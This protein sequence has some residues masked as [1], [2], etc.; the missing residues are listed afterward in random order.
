MNYKLYP[1]IGAFLLL[2]G[3]CKEG[4][5]EAGPK[6]GGEIA[7]D[8]VVATPSSV[9]NTININGSVLANEASELRNELPG[10]IVAL[11]F[12]EGA[13]V[14]KGELLLQIDD[15]EFQAQLRKLKSQLKIA[16]DDKNRKEQ[17]VAINGVSQ[18]QFDQ[19]ANLVE[20]LEAEM[21]SIQT[22]IRS[23]KI[24][25]PFSGRIGLRYVSPGSFL[26]SNDRIA[27]LVQDD[28]VKIEF[29]VPQR[30][31]SLLEVGQKIVFTNSASPDTFQADIY[32]VEPQIDV[33]T[34][35]IKVRAKC[36]N[37]D[38]K[39]VP[40]AFVDVVL[41]LETLPNAIMVPTFVIVPQLRGQKV[42][43]MRDGKA[44]GIEIETGLRTETSVQ[45]TSGISAGDTILTTAL[46]A[47]KDNMPVAVRQVIAQEQ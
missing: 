14:K 38:R 3:A 45:I 32:A 35:T 37:P 29:S 33:A 16:Q 19:A 9:A 22:K 25:A 39:L 7:V 11:P 34:R 46:L 18:E 36:A 42:F 31:A 23:T 10:R 20:E 47:L 1:F 6:R 5:N 21:Q 17:L 27:L 12:K 40:G 8:V 2:I 24:L 15:S 43:V 30:Y 41:N 28:P 4:T 13:Q 26:S 44:Q